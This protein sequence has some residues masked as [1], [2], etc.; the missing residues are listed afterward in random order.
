M[1]LFYFDLETTCTPPAVVGI[2][3]ISGLIEIDNQVVEEF[4]FKVRPRSDAFYSQDALDICGVTKEQVM[5]YE[6]IG[7][8]YSKLTALLSKYVDKY[9]KRD[10]FFM[11]GYNVAHF[12]AGLLRE[13]FHLNGDE[14][15]GSWF[16][17]VPLDV[18]VLAQLYLA[19]IRP[20]MPNF[21]QGTVAEKLG[22]EVDYSKLHDALYDIYICR[23]IFK[24]LTGG[25][26]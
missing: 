12:D 13:F 5:E 11:V 23:S 21:Q 26:Q 25:L 2:H 8:V 3:Q 18:I 15:F 20:D 17:S 4:N 6:P 14:Y 7:L 9:N 24:K 1:K 16:W 22:V 19:N 10:K